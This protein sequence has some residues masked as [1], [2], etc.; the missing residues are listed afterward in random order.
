MCNTGYLIF[1]RIEVGSI[2][3]VVLPGSVSGVEECKLATCA[4]PE[5]TNVESI[6]VQSFAYGSPLTVTCK[7][8]YHHDELESFT[9]ICQEDT[10]VSGAASCVQRVFTL[11]GTVVDASDSSGIQGASVSI[12]GLVARTLSDGSYAVTGVPFGASTLQVEHDQY[13]TQAHS[14]SISEDATH[15]F[16]L[17]KDLFC[18]IQFFVFR[19]ATRCVQCTLCYLI[20]GDPWGWS[21][22]RNSRVEWVIW[23]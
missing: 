21:V 8:G 18:T 11:L 19:L 15:N 12:D 16:S 2:S 1:E 3:I 20:Q 10:S 9:L 5:M 17:W 23:R 7:E 22:A 13:I 14:V 6:S 4:V